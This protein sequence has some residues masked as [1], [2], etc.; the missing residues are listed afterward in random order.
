MFIRGL[1]GFKKP[2]PATPGFEGS[3]TFPL[4]LKRAEI[5]FHPPFALADRLLNLLIF[6][7]LR[8][9]GTSHLSLIE[10]PSSGNLPANMPDGSLDTQSCGQGTRNA[11]WAALVP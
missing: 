8:R 5:V 1:Y 2:L 10:S 9:A 6:Q 4:V 7:L 11:V 3:G